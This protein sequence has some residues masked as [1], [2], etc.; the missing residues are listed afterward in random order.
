MPHGLWT[1]LHKFRQEAGDGKLFCIT[2]GVFPPV[3][4]CRHKEVQN[5]QE[6]DLEENGNPQKEYRSS[7]KQVIC[8]EIAS[9]KKEER[10]ACGLQ[11]SI[12]LANMKL[13]L[14]DPTI[15]PQWVTHASIK[16]RCF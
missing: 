12:S 15:Q 8:V 6:S 1:S 14:V 2:T 4:D 9:K 13:F 11:G 16:T 3:N 7:C 5:Y 10:L